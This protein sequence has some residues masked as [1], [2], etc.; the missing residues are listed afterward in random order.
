MEILRGLWDACH[1][2]L[3]FPVFHLVS[4]T[5]SSPL[6]TA[7]SDAFNSTGGWTCRVF[8]VCM[9]PYMKASL[10]KQRHHRQQQH[11]WLLLSG[12][13]IYCCG[14]ENAKSMQNQ[15]FHIYVILV[16]FALWELSILLLC[17]C[18]I[19]LGIGTR[20]LHAKYSPV[21][22]SWFAVIE[23]MICACTQ[24]CWNQHASDGT[25]LC[26]SAVFSTCTD[27]GSEGVLSLTLHTT[28]LWH[29]W[30]IQSCKHA[31]ITYLSIAF[32]YL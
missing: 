14:K 7:I 20:A 32:K 4:S 29:L 12:P 6:P 18:T 17:V 30:S 1:C 28:L 11:T 15:S 9:F 3:G 19:A 31:R 2:F 8:V 24:N 10:S 16:T 5:C 26:V 22:C 13:L 25:L 21:T 27:A 23:N